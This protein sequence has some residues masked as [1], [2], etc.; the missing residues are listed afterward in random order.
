MQHVTSYL[1]VMI[2][3]QFIQNSPLP[4]PFS[5]TLT[6]FFRCPQWK[7]LMVKWWELVYQWHEMYCHDLEVTSLNLSRVELGVHS[8][9]VLIRTW[10][11]NKLTCRPKSAPLKNSTAC[12]VVIIHKITVRIRN[13]DIKPL[14][15][16]ILCRNLRSR[17]CY[18]VALYA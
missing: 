11:K 9:S 3:N 13:K 17:L 8:T 18:R 1:T 7:S 4:C 14:W 15:R 16:N 2:L 5:L 6:K 12:S 10:S